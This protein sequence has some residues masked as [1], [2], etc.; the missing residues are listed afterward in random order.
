MNKYK[1]VFI[2]IFILLFK[3]CFNYEYWKPPQNLSFTYTLYKG[4]NIPTDEQLIIV[5]NKIFFFYDD[6]TR[7]LYYKNAKM[8]TLSPGLYRKPIL[9]TNTIFSFYSL[10]VTKDYNI[11]LY[12]ESEENTFEYKYIWS[13]EIKSLGTCYDTLRI[14]YEHKTKYGTIYNNRKSNKIIAINLENGKDIMEV[15]NEYYVT[16]SVIYSNYKKD[17]ILLIVVD[18]Q[19]IRFYNI[20]GYKSNW[21]VNDKGA[22]IKYKNDG[23]F[24]KAD[25]IDGNKILFA[26]YYYLLVFELEDVNIPSISFNYYQRLDGDVFKCVLGLKNGNA[27]VGT[28]YGYIYLIEYVNR[29]IKILDFKKRCNNAV[30]S[31]SYTNNCNEN[32]ESCYIFA[33]NCGYIYVFEISNEEKEDLI[34][35]DDINKG[36]LLLLLLFV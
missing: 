26:Y 11:Y 9:Y 31:L 12:E 25:F 34:T 6:L 36:W 23:P 1:N 33:A 2:S 13:K 27:L 20:Q 18:M 7:V 4:R 15:D 3:S 24:G 10:F 16:Q 8:F 5:Y 30:Y 19:G 35:N 22:L 14:Y 32:S 21:G 17:K 28:N 29:D